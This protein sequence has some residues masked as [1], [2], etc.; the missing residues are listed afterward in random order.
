MG[1]VIAYTVT[2]DGIQKAITNVGELRD[3][4]KKLNEEFRSTDTG[5]EKYDEL[6]NRQARLKVVQEQ[7]RQDVKRTQLELTASGR[8][9]GVAAGSYKALEAQAKLL[10]LEYNKLGNSAQEA[11]R[12]LEISKESQRIRAE[13]K[14]LREDIGRTGIEGAFSRALKGIKGDFA[15]LSSFL[16]GGVILGAISAVGPTL[17][18]LQDAIQYVADLTSEFVK[19]RGEVQQLTGA[20]GPELDRYATNIAGIAQTFGKETNEILIAANALT[21]QLT[22]DFDESLR[23][24][25]QGFLAGADANGEFLDTIR[26]YPAFF[27]EARLSGEQ[28]VSLIA[29]STEQGIFSDKGIDAIK[30]AELR[31]RELPKATVDALS[32]INISSEE[33]RKRIDEEGVGGAIQLVAERLKDFEDDS[34]EVGQVLADVF[35]G[36]GEDA[37]IAFIKSLADIDQGVNEL[38]DSSNDLVNR[39]QR[40]LEVNKAFAQSQNEL[41]VLLGSVDGTLE[42]VATRLQTEL[43]NAIIEIVKQAKEFQAIIAPIQETIRGI[44][45]DLGAITGRTGEAAEGFGNLGSVLEFFTIPM[46]RVIQFGRFLADRIKAVTGAGRELL[47]FLGI[48]NRAEEDAL[49]RQKQ[50]LQESGQAF[51]QALQTLRKQ[52]EEVQGAVSDT[53]DTTK[54]S[55]DSAN[56][57]FEILSKRQKELV[58]AIKDRALRGEPYAD[59]KKEYDEITKRLNGANKLF[60]AQNKV[61][62]ALAVGSL[63]EL[64]KSLSDLNKELDNTTDAEKTVA[65]LRQIDEVNENINNVLKQR[66]LLSNDISG[67]LTTGEEVDQSIKALEAALEFQRKAQETAGELPETDIQP[68]IDAILRV[69]NARIKSIQ[70]QYEAG[71]ISEEQ[72]NQARE[73][74]AAQ[75]EI[76]IIRER[77][78]L[79]E[80]GSEQYLELKQQEADIEFEIVRERNERI[81]QAQQELNQQLLQFGVTTA[82]A[83]S[84]Q[85][86]NVERN[87]TQ[88]EFDGKIEAIEQEYEA[89]IE[90]A[91]G[92]AALQASLEAEL[93]QKRA[94]IEREAARRRKEIARKEAAIQLALSIIEAIPDPFKI[95]QAFALG[96][97][98]LAFIDEQSFAT[99]GHTGEGSKNLE[100]MFG[101]DAAGIVH[102]REYVTPTRVLEHPRGAA[103]VSELERLRL[104][105]G[106]PRRVGGSFQTGGLTSAAVV[107]GAA[108]GSQVIVN[109][110]L[111]PDDQFTD[112]L[113]G[114]VAVGSKQGAIEGTRQG[115]KEAEREKQKTNVPQTLNDRL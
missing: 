68:A 29:R 47:E 79:Q 50:T 37:G 44:Q 62:A 9:A 51:D 104:D 10:E 63:A 55:V 19:L 42:S 39:Q 69:R 49:A 1:K 58:D 31:L 74:I 32:A 60:E 89:R 80:V 64:R 18:I 61:T 11:K 85:I 22:G 52:N 90:A 81:L 101:K 110:E 92:N 112:S 93:A 25:E 83:L 46:Q 33:I 36:P 14:E 34:R 91:E 57:S 23:L 53:A 73:A 76:A 15:N 96:A 95:A 99:G 8:V 113:A 77:L 75:S 115:F 72:Y 56:E 3:E 103:L 17:Q 13:L 97:I 28:F 7:L 78:A 26:E 5:T 48:I 20:T 65:I 27:R 66:A 106:Y 16:Q 35:A 86:L 109:V 43:L 30:E 105:L 12:K 38:I 88:E 84:S 82:N 108:G 67:F 2:V 6:V 41:A 98:Q 87:R 59:L 114:A 21:D 100:K 4:Q 45:D 70:E 54:A 107:P 40:L 71:V 24:I 94:E 111:T 102:K